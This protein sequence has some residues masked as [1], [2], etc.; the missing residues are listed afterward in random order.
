MNLYLCYFGTD[1]NIR[2]WI[3]DKKS[4]PILDGTPNIY[5]KKCKHI[6]AGLKNR[7]K[8]FDSIGLVTTDSGAK[9]IKLFKSKFVVDVEEVARNAVAKATAEKLIKAS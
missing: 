2:A 7:S 4:I 9:A 3:V 1:G 5:D 6:I 8:F